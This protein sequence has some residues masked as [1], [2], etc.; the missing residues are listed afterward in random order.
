[1]KVADVIAYLNAR[2]L[3]TVRD[4]RYAS[5][6]IEKGLGTDLTILTRG[7]GRMLV[8]TLSGGTR[9]I[10]E[11]HFD[12]HM[13]TVR[14]IG[15]QADYD[16]AEDLAGDVDALMVC[17]QSVPFGSTRALWVN[18]AGGPPTHMMTDRS[19]RAHFSCSYIV[20]AASGI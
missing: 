7:K 20:P 6:R 19:R 2:G 4:G 3:Q 14:M 8:I 16:D 13:L 15:T 17:P 1:M 11:Q 12:Q 10:I 5:I 18:R 9:S